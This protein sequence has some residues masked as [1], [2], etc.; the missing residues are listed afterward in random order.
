MKSRSCIG[1]V[2][3]N[4]AARAASFAA[5]GRQLLTAEAYTRPLSELDLSHFG[6]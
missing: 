6:M 5:D 3:M 4:G 2:K 1:Q